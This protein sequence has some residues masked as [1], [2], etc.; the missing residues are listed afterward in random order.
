M[1]M[2]IVFRRMLRASVMNFGRFP[3]TLKVIGSARLYCNLLFLQHSMPSIVRRRYLSSIPTVGD[4][5]RSLMLSLQAGPRYT[6][7]GA[8][9]LGI[10][11]AWEELLN[12]MFMV[13]P[14]SV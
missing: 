2:L 7:P 14:I 10:H 13:S 9:S 4:H 12:K 3:D 6:V 5:S 1:R 8:F 11:F